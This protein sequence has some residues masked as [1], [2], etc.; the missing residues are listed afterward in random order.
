MQ[1]R[2]NSSNFRDGAYR[3]EHDTKLSCAQFWK[4]R[5]RDEV[6]EEALRSAR[7]CPQH[8]WKGG[9]GLAD[10]RELPVPCLLRAGFVQT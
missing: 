10:E 7:L 4:I 3:T 2:A 1:Y 8:Q 5:F 6:Q 9:H